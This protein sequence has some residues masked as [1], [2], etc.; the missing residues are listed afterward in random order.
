MPAEIIRLEDQLKKTFEGDAGT[1]RPFSKPLKASR[2]KWQQ[3]ILSP[4]LTVSGN[5]FCIWAAHIAWSCGGSVGMAPDCRH[6]SGNRFDG[7]RFEV[8]GIQSDCAAEAGSTVA[9][10][11]RPK[12]DSKCQKRSLRYSE[13]R[14]FF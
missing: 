5:W 9:R 10:T 8:P 6:A 11:E 4:V 2:R 13:P 3:R 12:G 7:S 1:A 14:S